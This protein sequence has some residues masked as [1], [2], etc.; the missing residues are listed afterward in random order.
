MSG[1]LCDGGWMRDAPRIEDVRVEML[2]SS[3]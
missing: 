2:C 3:F 1:M